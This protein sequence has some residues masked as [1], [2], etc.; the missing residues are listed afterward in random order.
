[1]RSATRKKTGRD[2]A[3]LVWLH[4]FECCVPGCASKNLHLW[5]DEAA[6]GIEA[7]HLGPRGLSTKVPDRQAVPMCRFHHKELH[8]IGP[9]RFWGPTGTSPEEVIADFN[10]RFY[11]GEGT[12]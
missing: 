2:P 1:M 4:G 6:S 8:K 11:G 5:A 12:A 7:A 9:T 3:Y 10:K